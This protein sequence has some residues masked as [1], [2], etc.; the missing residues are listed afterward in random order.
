MRC[1]MRFLEDVCVCVCVCGG[2]LCDKQGI[3][4]EDKEGEKGMPNSIKKAKPGET[5]RNQAKPG[6]K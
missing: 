5:R 2:W 3:E 6:E 1:G 4:A